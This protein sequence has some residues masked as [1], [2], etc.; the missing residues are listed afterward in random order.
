MRR[1]D[2]RADPGQ[3]LRGR[4]LQP[5]HR[6]LQHPG[7][8]GRASRHGPPP[9][10]NHRARR[11]APAGNR[12]PGSRTPGRPRGVT[13]ASAAAPAVSAR[14]QAA[15]PGCRA[16]ASARPVPPAAQ[17]SR[18]IRR[19]FPQP[20]AGHPAHASRHS[21]MRSGPALTPAAAQREDASGHVP[22]PASQAAARR[23]RRAGLA[24]DPGMGGR[25]LGMGALVGRQRGD[26]VLHIR[27]QGRL[28]GQRSRR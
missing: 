27:R 15:P 3:Q 26:Q 6:V 19:R 2:A 14:A 28:E 20:P 8:Q 17:R 9:R 18:A 23:A 13:T 25:R 22:G 24:P 7:Q 1:A 5:R 10:P 11:T 4:Y 21:R 16:P 12:Q